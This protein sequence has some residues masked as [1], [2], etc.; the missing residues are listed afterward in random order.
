MNPNANYYPPGTSLEQQGN[1]NLNRGQLNQNYGAM[2]MN[3]G[4]Q[5]Q[6]Y[7]KFQER[8]GVQ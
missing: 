6:N 7:G 5:T 1:H 4:Y 3:Q 2:Q 8:M